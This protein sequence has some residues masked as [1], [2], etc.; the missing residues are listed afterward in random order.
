[1]E[2]VEERKDGIKIGEKVSIMNW[3]VGALLFLRMIVPIITTEYQTQ[4]V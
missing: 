2:V 4:K 3:S 1:M